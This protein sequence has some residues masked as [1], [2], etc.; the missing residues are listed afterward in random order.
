MKDSN[1]LNRIVIDPKIMVG[2]PV[3]KGT[4]LTVQHILGLMAQGMSMQELLEEYDNLTEKDILACL[5]F[6]RDALA[7]NLNA[8]RRHGLCEYDSYSQY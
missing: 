3:I 8:S 1:L 7:E 5:A 2:K 6:A 4:R